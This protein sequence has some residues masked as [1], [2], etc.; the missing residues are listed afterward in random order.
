[1]ARYFGRQL[2]KQAL[3]QVAS[4]DARRIQLLD[5]PERLLGLLLRGLAARIADHLMQAELEVAVL[6]QVVNDV[7]GKLLDRRVA[8]EKAELFGQIIVKRTR[9]RGHVLHGVLLAV[10][11]LA[12][13]GPAPP[14]P[15]V[16][17][18][19][20]VLV[21]TAQAV[22]FVRLGLDL[23][24]SDCRGSRLFAVRLRRCGRLAEIHQNRVLAQFLLDPLLQS[25]DRQLQDFHRL[26]HP[27]RHPQAHL[28]PHLLRGIKTHQPILSSITRRKSKR[29]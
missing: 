28:G 27:R 2:Q 17:K 26:D 5:Q 23:G 7:L 21:Q 4:A 10:A 6:V 11:F 9:T 3:T 29:Q 14:R 24:L 15:L 1:M 20:P 25:H 8:I 19:A 13:G 16:I 22:E 18:L 12:Q